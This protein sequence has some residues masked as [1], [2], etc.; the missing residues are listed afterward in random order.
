MAACSSKPPPDCSNRQTI[1]AEKDGAQLSCDVAFKATG[2][3]TLLAGRS[4]RPI[5]NQRMTKILRDR[6]LEDP[7]KMEDWTG[8]VDTLWNELWGATGMEGA[9]KR[10]HHVWQA[11]AEKGPMS[12]GDPD[13]GNIFA[14]T[15]S[16]WSSSDAEEL[17]LTEMD[18]EGWI[19]YSS[20]CRE[21]QGAGPLNLSVSDRVV[22]YRLLCQRF[23]EGDRRQKVAYLAMGPYWRNIRSRWQS[24][25]Y[26]EQQDWIAKAPLP[27][28]MTET[29][30][31]YALTLLKGDLATH[32]DV[33][34]NVL[35]PF[36]MRTAY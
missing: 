32:A 29:S 36:A 22:L 27:P 1:L 5:D 8:E 24:A 4:P 31:G 16:I 18:I 12:T 34:H 28:P 11:Q 35:G 9:E 17:A 23:K 7:V 21:V 10:G 33:L 6:W 2:V 20:L 25:T 15:M 30:L 3:L 13:L 26:E 14:H 19:F